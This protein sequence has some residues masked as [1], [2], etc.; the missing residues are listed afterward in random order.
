MGLSVLWRGVQQQGAE[1]GPH[2]AALRGEA[3]V[4]VRLHHLWTGVQERAPTESAQG[5][6]VQGQALGHWPTSPCTLSPTDNFGKTGCTPK[7]FW[8]NFRHEFLLLKCIA[9]T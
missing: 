8:G 1:E 6:E 2:P 7:I 9:Q 4:A 3:K 5:E